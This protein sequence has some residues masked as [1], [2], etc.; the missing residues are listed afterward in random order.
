MST[1]HASVPYDDTIDTSPQRQ[2]RRIGRSISAVFAGLLVIVVL[3]NLI[4]FVLHSAG[5]YPPVGQSMADGL[6][7]LALAYRTVDAIIGSYVAASLAPSRPLWHALALGVIGIVLS[8][9]GVLATLAG[10]PDLGPPW[11]PLALVAIC[12]P[13]T[14]VGGTLAGARRQAP[15]QITEA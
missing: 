14:Y 4:D 10:G 13:C 12:L 2:P 3:D 7:L 15:E 8:S 6:F 9:L 11:Y 5:V 1:L